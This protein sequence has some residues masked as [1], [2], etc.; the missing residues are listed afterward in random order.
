[1]GLNEAQKNKAIEL[2]DKLAKEFDSKKAKEFIENMKSKSWY[3]EFK[4]LYDMV[5]DNSYIISNK[6][7][8]VIMGALAYVIFPVDVIPDF[9]PVIGWLDDMFVLNLTIDSIKEEIEA[10]K[11][12][13]IETK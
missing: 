7:K 3:E 2:R 9:I 10:Y 1:M 5:T 12:H 11:R 6:T 4:L 8:L 13:K